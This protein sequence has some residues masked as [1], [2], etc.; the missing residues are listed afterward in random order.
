M[1]PHSLHGADTR[2]TLIS[3]DHKASATSSL[4]VERVVA[5]DFDYH[6]VLGKN[7]GGEACETMVHQGAGKINCQQK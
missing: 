3:Y 6:P 4:M 5:V 1:L 2:N 7:H